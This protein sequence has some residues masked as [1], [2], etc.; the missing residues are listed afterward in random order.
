MPCLAQEPDEGSDYLYGFVYIPTTRLMNIEVKTSQYSGAE[1]G[2]TEG[3]LFFKIKKDG[4]SNLTT[5]YTPHTKYRCFQYNCLFPKWIKHKSDGKSSQPYYGN[6][7]VCYNSKN[8]NIH[9][10]H[11]ADLTQ[12]QDTYSSSSPSIC[13]TIFSENGTC[14]SFTSAH[15]ERWQYLKINLKCFKFNRK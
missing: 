14:N 13:H 2:G 9:L 10:Y 15:H 4:L 6:F 12:G 8:K 3:M 7:M 11:G 1:N 5:T